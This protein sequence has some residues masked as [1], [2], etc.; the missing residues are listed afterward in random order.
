MSYG[1]KRCELAEGLY[2]GRWK[3]FIIRAVS[4]VTEQVRVR[5]SPEQAQYF[6]LAKFPEFDYREHEGLSW[7]GVEAMACRVSAVH[8]CFY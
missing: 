5:A 3:S 7:P 6:P 8:K 2:E 1:P 4:L